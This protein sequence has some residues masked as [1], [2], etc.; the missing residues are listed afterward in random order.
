MIL[1]QKSCFPGG[2]CRN[3]DG[4]P[5]QVGDFSNHVHLLFLLNKKMALV[6][7]VEEIKAHSSK[8]IKT[9]GPSYQNFYWQSGYGAFSVNPSEADVVVDYIKQQKEH[10]RTKTFEEEYRGFLKKYRVA[11]DEQYV[12]D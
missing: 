12:W 7:I 3:N 11:Y 5:V 1:S 6:T 10:H 9:K 4:N 2:I 8:W